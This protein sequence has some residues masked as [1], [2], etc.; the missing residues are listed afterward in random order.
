MVGSIALLSCGAGSPDGEGEA[1]GSVS[2]LGT[3]GSTGQGAGGRSGSSGI[4]GSPTGTGIGGRGMGPADG[5]AIRPDG[6]GARDASARLDAANAVVDARADRGGSAPFVDSGAPM[7]NGITL[8]AAAANT[9]RLIGAAFNTAHF[10]EVAY[11]NAAGAEFNFATPENEMKWS[12][13]EPSQG[14]FTYGGGDSVVNFAAQHGIK[15]KGHTLVWHNQLPAWVSSLSGAAAVRPAMIN[16][17]TQVM[18]H[19]QG[20]VIGWDVVNEAWNDDGRT[21]RADVFQLALGNGYIDEAFQAAHA[22]DP[23]ALL[24]YND[25][26]IEGNSTKANS[27]FSMIQSM[28]MRGIPIDG[29]GMQMHVGAPNSGPTI[30]QFVANMLR[31]ADLGLQIVVSEFDV[32][33]CTSTQAAQQT[34]YH[35]I[36]AACMAE[37][38]CTAVTI[39]GITDKFSWLNG[40]ACASAMGLLFDANYVKKP[41]YTGVL[42][43]LNGR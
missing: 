2:T 32:Q 18:T 39:W 37:P 35:D 1:G 30:A 4:G 27:A 28:K 23:D 29:V 7:G 3:G 25:F 20:K 21:L 42:D 8:Q 10:D 41:A 5:G 40:Q 14:R 15:V 38:A 11:A 13:T 34:R 33:I 43:A 17:I 36:V 24:Y 19:F 12:A 31:Y 16:H 6:A 9:G 26:G 22:A